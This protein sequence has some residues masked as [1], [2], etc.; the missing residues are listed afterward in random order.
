M[1]KTP[2]YHLF[3]CLS[4]CLNLP[5]KMFKRQGLIC[6]A[7]T[8]LWVL[9]GFLGIYGLAIFKSG[10]CLGP[11]GSSEQSSPGFSWMRLWAW[12]GPWLVSLGQPYCQGKESMYGI[13]RAASPVNFSASKTHLAS[14]LHPE[15]L[16]HVTESLQMAYY[17]I[18]LL[19]HWAST[20]MWRLGEEGRN[21][22]CT[23]LV[24]FF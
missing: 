2:S 7:V 11:G 10:H 13:T 9:K 6:L 4:H 15:T 23:V 19:H 21:M 3:T 1:T 18:M 16:N 5:V 8:S 24:I 14:M 20:T 22:E 17:K 12:Q